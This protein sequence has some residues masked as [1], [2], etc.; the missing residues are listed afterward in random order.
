M[1]AQLLGNR[2]NFAG[3]NTL[4]I[5]LRQR[6]NQ[7]PLR[8]LVA[9][10]QFGREPALAIL[11]HAQLELANPRDQRPAVIARAI[12]QPARRPLALLGSQRLRHLHFEN[13]LE[14]RPHQRMT[15]RSIAFC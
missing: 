4:H 9:L 11:R 8:A 15:I 5:H 14:G 1:A 2:L 12:T 3:R 6:R 10:E 7:R 13:L